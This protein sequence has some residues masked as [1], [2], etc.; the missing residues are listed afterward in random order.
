MH[1][2]SLT[3]INFVLTSIR[4]LYVLQHVL[5][6]VQHVLYVVQHVLYVV[7]H[8][9]YVVLHVLLLVHSFRRLY[10]KILLLKHVNFVTV[11]CVE[12]RGLVFLL[13]D[14]DVYLNFIYVWLFGNFTP[15][16]KFQAVYNVVFFFNFLSHNSL[17]FRP[18]CDTVSWVCIWIC[19]LYHIR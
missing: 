3:C 16:A 5:Y 1:C 13:L 7:Q 9:L 12:D 15:E 18:Q 10:W 14:D 17:R 8:V 19:D 6:V 2:T 11:L 4:V